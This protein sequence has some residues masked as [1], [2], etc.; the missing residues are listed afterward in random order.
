LPNKKLLVAGGNPFY[1]HRDG[2]MF[3]SH[4]VTAQDFA[5]MALL[6]GYA[7]PNIKAATKAVEKTEDAPDES[8]SAK[9]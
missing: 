8:G 6:A 1:P 3:G 4:F 9:E 7:K 2:F 5:A